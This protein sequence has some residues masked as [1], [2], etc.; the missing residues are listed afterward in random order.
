MPTRIV[1]FRILLVHPQG[2]RFDCLIALPECGLRVLPL[3]FEKDPL[4]AVPVIVGSALGKHAVPEGLDDVGTRYFVDIGDENHFA[5]NHLRWSLQGWEDLVHHSVAGEM[6][7]VPGI[8]E[9]LA[10]DI[11]QVM[12]NF[13]VPL[14]EMVPIVPYV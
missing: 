10:R 9:L 1:Y 11:T 4:E 3:L 5:H 8:G 6:F 13:M 2:L 14:G 7:T 12:D